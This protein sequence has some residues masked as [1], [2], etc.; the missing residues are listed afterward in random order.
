M[1]PGYLLSSYAGSSAFAPTDIA[2]LA[3]WLDASDSATITKDGSNRVSQWNDKSGNSNH[4]VQATL[5]NQPIYSATGLNSLPALT[6]TGSPQCMALTTNLT[7]SN[8]TLFMVSKLNSVISQGFFG[9]NVGAGI[10]AGGLILFGSTPTFSLFDQGIDEADWNI[11]I[12][13]GTSY[14]FSA[15]S[16]T[17]AGSSLGYI[18]STLQTRT[19][20]SGST[21]SFEIGLVGSRRQDIYNLNGAYSEALIY[22]ANLSDAD[23]TKVINYLT[24]KW[25]IV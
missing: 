21:Y 23:H 18:N 12:S 25:S 17:V 20:V 9:R 15:I 7:G 2:N 19:G 8:Y 13:T 22:Q 6:Q 14:I 11:T 4:A 24:T 3:V 16:N 5:A 10:A 1:S